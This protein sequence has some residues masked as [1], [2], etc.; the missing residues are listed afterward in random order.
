M[1]AVSSDALYTT[2]ILSTQHKKKPDSSP[3]GFFI[4][5]PKTANSGSQV[6]GVRKAQIPR[7]EINR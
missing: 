4:L 7:L 5:M 6:V 1:I 3:S 2:S